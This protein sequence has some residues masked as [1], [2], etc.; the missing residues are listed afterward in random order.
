MY[1]NRGTRIA[2]PKFLFCVRVRARGRVRISDLRGGVRA[3]LLASLTIQSPLSALPRQA[4]IE[5]WTA[6][7]IRKTR[8]TRRSR[9]C[10]PRT[11]HARARRRARTR[12][13]PPAPPGT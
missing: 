7:I 5:E 4:H 3:R 1:D 13:S 9:S 12:L 6:A 2:H 10:R 8:W 11:A